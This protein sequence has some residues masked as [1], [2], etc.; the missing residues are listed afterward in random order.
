MINDSV[1]EELKD[2]IS[3]IVKK[4]NLERTPLIPNKIEMPA[5]MPIKPLPA[6]AIPKPQIPIPGKAG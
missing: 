5:P 3:P 4:I 1:R 2:K 6:A